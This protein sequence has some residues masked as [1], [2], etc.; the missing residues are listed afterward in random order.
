MSEHQLYNHEKVEMLLS[1]FKGTKN[2]LIPILQHVQ[3]QFG[4]LPERAMLEIARYVSIPESKVYATAT[5]YSEFRFEPIG[6]KHI[7]VCQGTACH[8]RGAGKI[9]ETIERQLEIKE[10]E[11]TADRQYSLETVACIGCCALAPCM[12]VNKETV[13]GNL[14]PRKAVNIIS[15]PVVEEEKHAAKNLAG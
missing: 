2:E 5:F 14:T 11:T 3:M 4:Y 1:D 13:H 10:G 9:L 15:E 8:I 6:E 12:T 7:S